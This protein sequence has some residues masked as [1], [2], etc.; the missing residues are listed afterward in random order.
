MKI[1]DI[2]LFIFH[3]ANKFM[4]ETARKRCNI[5][6]NKFFIEIEDIGNTVSN[7]IP[8]AMHKAI[9]QKHKGKQINCYCQALE[10]DF[11]W[12]PLF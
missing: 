4:L 3:Q 11:H 10:S 2:D 9:E 1:E 8:I 12:V 6:E 7:T 5:P